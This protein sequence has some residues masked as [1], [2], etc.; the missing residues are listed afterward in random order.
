VSA[1]AVP[2]LMLLAG[3]IPLP[4]DESPGYVR[5]RY[6]VDLVDELAH[7]ESDT[8]KVQGWRRRIVRLAYGGVL[9]GCLYGVNGDSSRDNDG[10]LLWQPVD[11]ARGFGASDQMVRL[12][13]IDSCSSH[14]YLLGRRRVVRCAMRDGQELWLSGRAAHRPLRALAEHLHG[15]ASVERPG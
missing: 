12:S 1:A 2:A 14:V 10:R 3:D 5:R 15:T 4:D 7:I 11:T 6:R 13:E 8:W 9:T